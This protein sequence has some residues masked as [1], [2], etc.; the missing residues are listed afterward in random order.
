MIERKIEAEVHCCLSQVVT[1]AVLMELKQQLLLLILTLLFA[2]ATPQYVRPL[3]RKTLT[4]PWDSI[5]KAHSSYPQQVNQ[6]LFH[7]S[8]SYS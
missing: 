6:P 2:T 7:S 5:S 4:I 8:C 1:V 3:P